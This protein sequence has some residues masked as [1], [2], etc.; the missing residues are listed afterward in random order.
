MGRGVAKDHWIKI[1]LLVLCF[2][3]AA[4][5]A[6]RTQPKDDMGG[7]ESDPFNDPFFT[8]QPESDEAALQPGEA[9]TEKLE[10]PEKPKSVLEQ[11]EGLIMGTL[12]IGASIAK[13]MAIPFLY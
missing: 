1:F 8:Q 4:C 9:L 6:Q 13:M 10:E 11:S 3:V 12:F 5:S 7:A 2:G